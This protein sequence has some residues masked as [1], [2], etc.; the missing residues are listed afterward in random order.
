MFA[1]ALHSFARYGSVVMTGIGLLVWLA[2][3]PAVVLAYQFAT[4][5]GVLGVRRWM[6]FYVVVALVSLSGVYLEYIGFEWRTLG[7][8]RRGPGHL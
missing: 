8:D 5:R 2:P 4:R 3:I 1:Q 6:M 7:R